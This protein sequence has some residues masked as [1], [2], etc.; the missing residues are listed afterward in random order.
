MNYIK[1]NNL[2]GSKLP[3]FIETNGTIVKAYYDDGK[4]VTEIFYDKS[5]DKFTTSLAYTRAYVLVPDGFAVE[6]LLIPGT[7]SSTDNA[8]IA[9]IAQEALKKYS[10]VLQDAI[11]EYMDRKSATSYLFMYKNTY[12]HLRLD[13]TLDAVSKAVTFG[14]LVITGYKTGDFSNCQKYQVTIPAPA[15]LVY[16]C[17]SCDKSTEVEFQGGCHK[18]IEGCLI[19]AGPICVKCNADYVKSAYKCYRECSFFFK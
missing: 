13:A 11:I 10:I 12:G 17:L 15:N 1:T 8:T 5:A 18:I 4:S 2:A 14:R 7:P 9:R 6:T 19:Q 16:K 3:F